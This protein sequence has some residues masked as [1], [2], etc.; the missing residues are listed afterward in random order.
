MTMSKRYWLLPAVVFLLLSLGL[1]A[2]PPK[3]WTSGDIHEAIQKLNFLGSVLYVAAH[4]DDENT[5]MISYLA[6]EVKANVAYLSLT[7]GDGGQNLIGPE[8]EDLLGV[9]RTQELLAARR[10]DGGKQL[11]SRA[12]DFGFSKHPD[13]TLRIWDKNAVLSDVVWAIRS[14]QP[15]V[16]INRFDHESAGR[17]HGHHTASAM[18]AY[19]AFDLAGRKDM[20]P[21]QLRYVTPWQPRRLFFNTS[22]WFYGSQDAFAKAD[23]SDL[24]SMD[25]GVYYPIKGKSN[26][27]IAAESRSM[28]KC[29]GMGATGARGSE[30]EYLKILKGD[31]PKGKADIFEGINTT[32]SRVKGGEPIGALLAEAEKNFNYKNPATSVPMLIKAYRL[33]K[34]LP[35]SYWKHVKSA[36]IQEVILACMGLFTEAIASDYSATPGQEIAVTLEV[37]NRSAVNLILQSILFLPEGQDTLLKRPIG[38]NEQFKLQRKLRIPENVG[39]TN[40]YWL[41][42]P[43]Q[44]GMYTVDNQLLRGLP[45]TPRTFRIRLRLLVEGEPLDY[46]IDVIHKRTDDVRGEVYRPFEITPPIFTNMAEKVYVFSNA[47]PQTVEVILKSGAPNVSG[48]VRLAHPSGWRVEP[49]QIDFALKIKGEEQT[50][51]FSVFPPEAQSEGQ[52]KPVAT[53]DGKSYGEEVVLIDYEHIP[54]QTILRDAAAKVAKIDLKKAGDRIGYYMGAGDNIPASLKQIGYQVTLLDD[55]DLT[56]E[57]LR[58]YDAVIMGVRAYNT[59]ERLKF[60]QPKLFEYVA[61]GGTLI[62][63]YNTSFELVLP[64]EQLAPYMLKLSRDRVTMEDAEVR[65][66]KPDHQVLHFPNK[67]TT[68]DFEGWIQERGLY[69]PSEWGPEFTAVL[70]CN[71]PGES[72]KDGG[73][74]IAKYGKGHYIYTGYSWFRELPGGVPG[75]FRLFANMISIGKEAKP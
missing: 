28:H 42:T 8:I 58:Q 75:A 61:N 2:Q 50:V 17:T 70:S 46:E 40:A 49:P 22:W 74:L 51:R 73:L 43:W 11:F 15:D 60:A 54:T 66:L 52:V 33:I 55:R 56:P 32:W 19:E 34:A 18:L 26:N 37:T 59:R 27:E 53:V 67:I 65:F 47:A 12:N 31:L 64:A 44:L 20:Y 6:N 25:I 24:M 5:R 48:S 35:D 71:D 14:W 30:L 69:F 45:E 13:E 38:N 7:R 39:L 29:Q 23:K 62:V 3:R 1:Y 16:I 9:I 63:Q 21:E 57:N 4:P 68:K 72:P 41:N 36:D 10:I